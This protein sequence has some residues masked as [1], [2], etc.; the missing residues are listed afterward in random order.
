MIPVINL[1]GYT[2]DDPLDRAS[3]RTLNLL[4]KVVSAVVSMG[5][6]YVVYFVANL[7][8]LQYNWLYWVEC[9]V[10]V[11]VFSPLFV[12][13][14][15]SSSLILIAIVMVVG[16][17]LDIYVEAH[18]RVQGLQALWTYPQGTFLSPLP[19]FI[20]TFIVFFGDGLMMGP[21]CLWLCRVIAG[22]IYPVKSE[23]RKPTKDEYESLFAKE[24]TEET[25]DKPQRDL[26]FYV[27][28]ILG[29]SYLA[30][31]SILIVGLIGVSPWP[32]QIEDLLTM[33]YV[34]PALAVNTFM[35]ITLMVMLALIAAYN[36]SLRW[37]CTLGLFGGHLVSTIASI[38]FFIINDPSNALYH[39]FLR[40]SAIVDGGMVVIFLII[41]IYYRDLASQFDDAKEF[42]EFYSLPNR[43]M[44]R[45]Y[46]AFGIV[47]LL[48]VPGVIAAR[49]YLDGSKG[50]GAAYGFPDPQ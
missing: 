39:D 19:F 24:W 48:M 16:V 50:L 23:D 17:P 25:V 38:W 45:F 20:K 4:P 8:Q 11:F 10:F 47:T 22:K 42:P 5:L 33:T 40:M 31:L 27:L 37:H 32:K 49:Y 6:L 14:R 7:A 30:Y 41:L 35:K 21:V 2:A 26:A 34:N 3:D 18:Q 9:A 36:K 43:L 44:K 15:K 13:L 28:L 1:R 12:T 46:L 29:I